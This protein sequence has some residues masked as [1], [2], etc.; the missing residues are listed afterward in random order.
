MTL[1]TE[2]EKVYITGE[3]GE[4]LAEVT[5]PVGEDGVA[6]INHTFVSEALRGQGV[7]GR[8]MQAAADTLRSQGRKAVA[9]CSYAAGWFSKHAEYQD[10]LAYPNKA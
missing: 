8:L 9:S 1:H 10:L 5:F 7:A 4:V 6:D 2:P 3:T